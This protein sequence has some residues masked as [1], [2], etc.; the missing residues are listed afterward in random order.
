MNEANKSIFTHVTKRETPQAWETYYHLV[1]SDRWEEVQKRVNDLLAKG[2]QPTGGLAIGFN[3]GHIQ[4]G[5]AMMR[6]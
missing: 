4:Y 5:Q 1:V 6:Y 3:D 2:W